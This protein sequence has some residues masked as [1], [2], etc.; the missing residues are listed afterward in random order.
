[1]KSF[2]LIIILV[3][4]SLSLYVNA[5]KSGMRK[6]VYG[7][8]NPPGQSLSWDKLHNVNLPHPPENPV[9]SNYAE[10]LADPTKIAITMGIPDHVDFEH[11]LAIP[12]DHYEDPVFVN[13]HGDEITTDEAVAE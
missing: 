1:M 4:L 7:S 3:I 5:K 6:G 8:A 12:G 11:N 13:K 10:M 2:K 9:T